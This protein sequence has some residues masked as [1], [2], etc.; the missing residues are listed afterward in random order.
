[1]GDGLRPV[2]DSIVEK[3]DIEINS[4]AYVPVTVES[5]FDATELF[6]WRTLSDRK[7]MCEFMFDVESGRF[8]RMALMATGCELHAYEE[9]AFQPNRI[10]IGH[11][12][13][14]PLDGAKQSRHLRVVESTQPMWIG[15]SMNRRELMIRFEEQ[16]A[17]R[18]VDSQLG[19]AWG[20]EASDELAYIR[21]YEGPDDM[22][23]HLIADAGA[24]SPDLSADSDP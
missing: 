14:R 5:R 23:G 3:I 4:D 17:V 13:F 18:E 1:M 10:E 2:L 11:P 22:V 7:R 8:Y 6:Y 19:I 21:V 12:V 15:I 24:L 16:P 20:F 9:G